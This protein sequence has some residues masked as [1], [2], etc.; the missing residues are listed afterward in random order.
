MLVLRDAEVTIEERVSKLKALFDSGLS[1]TIMG[2]DR[3]MELFGEVKVKPMI[4][5]R[6]AALLNRQRIIIDGL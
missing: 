6:E 2:Y 5:P 4:R 1:F 3:L